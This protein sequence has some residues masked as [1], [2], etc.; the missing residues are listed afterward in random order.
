LHALDQFLRIPSA[1]VRGGGGISVFPKSHL[2][3]LRVL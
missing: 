3:W 2:G 1:M